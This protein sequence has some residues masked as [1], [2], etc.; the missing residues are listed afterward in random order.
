[1]DAQESRRQ[2]SN[3][4]E[5]SSR[6]ARHNEPPAPMTHDTDPDVLLPDFSIGICLLA[7]ATIGLAI[8]LVLTHIPF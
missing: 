3:H 8:A 4:D 7:L 6:P 5:G 2:V 1:M